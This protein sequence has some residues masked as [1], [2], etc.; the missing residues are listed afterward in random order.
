MLVQAPTHV[1]IPNAV[2]YLGARP[3]FVDCRRE[4]YNMDLQRAEELIT[5]KTKAIVVQHTFGV[6]VDMDAACALAERHGL[7]LIEDCVHALGAR[8]RGRPIG[9]FGIASFF[10][11]EETKIPSP[12]PWAAWP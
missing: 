7:F 9:S 5:P 8:F 4:T 3:V 10:S 1:V 2:T 6:P 12:A 11:T